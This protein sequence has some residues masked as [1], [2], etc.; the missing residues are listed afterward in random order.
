MQGN[1]RSQKPKLVLELK[2]NVTKRRLSNIEEVIE[3]V[4]VSIV[5]S[6]N[7]EPLISPII[8]VLP[9]R[10]QIE[11]ENL[12]PEFSKKI[13]N[14]S[15]KIRQKDFVS[16]SGSSERGS[17]STMDPLGGGGIPPPIPPLPPFPPIGLPI[18][19]PQDLV[20]VD[21]PSNLPKFYETKDEDPSR[22]ME[23]FIE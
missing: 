3:G 21:I 17:P 16:T 19:V 2:K 5:G 10:T 15:N 8:E 18:I 13:I 4:D 20:S 22:H 1:T 14:E 12:P 9:V 11:E 23:R 7:V 6:L